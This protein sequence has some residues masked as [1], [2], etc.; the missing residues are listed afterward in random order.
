MTGLSQKLATELAETAKALCQP[1][2]GILAADESTGTIKKRFDGVGIENTEQQRAAYRD[3]LFSTDTLGKYISGAILFEETL[4]Q[5]NSSGTAMV[6]ILKKQGIIPG[7]KVDKGVVPLPT[8]DGETSTQGLDGLANRCAEYYKQGARF[9]KWRA[10]LTIDEEKGKPSNQSIAETAYTLARYAVI[11]QSEG[12]VPIIEPEILTDGKQSIITCAER[13]EKVLAATFKCCNDQNVLLEGALLKPNMVTPGT[14]YSP[15]ASPD[16]IAFFTVRTLKRTVP[17][18]LPGVVF[19]SGGMSEEDASLALNA[20][21]K[22]GPF[23][24]KMSFSY[25]RALQASCLK[26]YGG[27]TENRAA[28]QKVLLER[29]KANSEATLGK[30]AGGAG[31]SAAAASLFE[32]K[33]VY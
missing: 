29:A 8:T 11:C 7:I 20:I 9:A 13:T 21:N 4:Y 10:V 28:A 18:A 33:Y 26:A 17:P 2:K 12:L 14:D 25:G 15:K 23:D 32:K 24:T 5:K 22:L 19:L 1:G 30:Y 3:M 6:D 16:E 27:K 31:G